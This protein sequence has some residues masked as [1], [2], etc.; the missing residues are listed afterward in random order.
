MP[1]RHSVRHEVE[2]LIRRGNIFYWRP[3]VPGCFAACPP[4][5]H[6]SSSL[7]MSDHKK[8]KVMAR[9]LNLRLA[10][11]K[12]KSKDIMSTKEQLQR[13]FKCAPIQH[14]DCPCFNGSVRTTIK[15]INTLFRKGGTAANSFQ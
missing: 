5:S 2:N 9:Q 10:E 6:L 3:R 13:L 12:L 15:R 8:A 14:C 7:Q 1:V 11:M 4:G